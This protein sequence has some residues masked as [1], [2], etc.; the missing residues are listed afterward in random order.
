MMSLLSAQ[1]FRYRRKQLDRASTRLPQNFEPPKFP[2]ADVSLLSPPP[3]WP[4]HSMALVSSYKS[5]S[6][7]GGYA[8]RPLSSVGSRPRLELRRPPSPS[9]RSSRSLHLVPSTSTLARISRSSSIDRFASNAT[10]ASKSVHS[11]SP[12]RA[13]APQPALSFSS[14]RQG[15]PPTGRA[16]SPSPIR[17]IASAPSPKLYR[18]PAVRLSTGSPTA[19]LS[20]S[21][22]SRSPTPPPP[23]ATNPT[24]QFAV[25]GDSFCGVFSLLGNHCRVE[26][27]SGASAR[28]HRFLAQLRSCTR[29]LIPRCM[30]QGLGNP[31]S[32]RQLGERILAELER[33]R[34]PNV[35]FMFGQVDFAVNYLWFV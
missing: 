34:P 30:Q 31:N 22:S 23:Y 15:G 11:P 9:T 24:N 16:R 29:S 6:P 20:L 27:S 2:D 32:T 14:A 10:R 5:P 7:A 33:T 17:A 28:V 25:F 8:Q 26:R 35:L 3:A 18:P 13:L 1:A 4:L 21:R 19:S 12:H